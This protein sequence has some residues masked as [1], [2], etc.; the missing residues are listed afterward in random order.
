MINTKLF[1]LIQS[2]MLYNQIE[3]IWTFKLFS[4]MGHESIE[5]E[6]LCKVLYCEKGRK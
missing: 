2:N 3:V 4:L 1:S 6:K 5:V